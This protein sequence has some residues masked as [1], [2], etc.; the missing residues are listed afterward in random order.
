MRNYLEQ[1]FKNTSLY[2]NNPLISI[3]VPVYNTGSFLKSCLKSICNQTYK[4]IEVIVI[5]DGSTD[6][7][8]EI[9]EEYRLKDSRIRG[10]SSPKW[11]D[12]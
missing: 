3:I 1:N 2:E 4:N 7:S 9:L 12:C 5:N 10:I 11:R 6:N 8:K